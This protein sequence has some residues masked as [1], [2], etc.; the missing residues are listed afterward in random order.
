MYYGSLLE[1]ELKQKMQKV[2]KYINSSNKRIII[3][4]SDAALYMIPLK[5]NNGV[6]DMVLIGNLGKDGEEKIISQLKNMENYIVLL[7]KEK[8]S[9]QESDK[10]R[11]YI[12]SYWINTGVIEDMNIYEKLNK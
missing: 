9:Y 11:K 2:I 5:L 6:L 12:E 10:I 8:K 4:S 1:E 3:L 7:N